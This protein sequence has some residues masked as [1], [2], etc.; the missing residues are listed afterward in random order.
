MKQ[1]LLFASLLL[2]FCV[3]AEAQVQDD[4]PDPV[5]SLGSINIMTNTATVEQLLANRRVEMN[6]KDFQVKKFEVSLLFIDANGD[7][8]YY[9][10]FTVKGSNALPENIYQLIEGKPAELKKIFIEG[11]EVVGPSK[12]TRYLN[13]IILTCSK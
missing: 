8:E 10:P 1:F 9:G 7:D 4:N 5:V 11:V 12:Q 3:N 13:P 2:S 6:R